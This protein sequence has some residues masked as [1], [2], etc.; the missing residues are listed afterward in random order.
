[1][2]SCCRRV[3][4]VSEDN[5]IKFRRFY[6]YDAAVAGEVVDV[7]RTLVGG[8]AGLLNMAYT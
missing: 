6:F 7:G 4:T 3:M 2:V 1:M 8:G 5:R